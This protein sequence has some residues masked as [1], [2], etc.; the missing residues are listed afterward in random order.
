VSVMLSN[1]AL[2]K[3]LSVAIEASDRN[4][5]IKALSESM[6]DFYVAHRQPAAYLLISDSDGEALIQSAGFRE[7]VRYTDD[8][9]RLRLPLGLKGVL[10]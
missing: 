8:P 7:A 5:L 3:T 2:D 9:G 4:E 10:L 6:R 1:K